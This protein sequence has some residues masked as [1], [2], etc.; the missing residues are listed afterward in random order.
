MDLSK[1]LA[2]GGYPGLFKMVSQMKTG[3]VVESIV[4]GKRM[5]AY[6]TQKILALEDISIYT[7]A[8]DVPL[9]EVFGLLFKKTSGKAG[10]DAQKASIKELSEFLASVLPNYDKAR[11]YNS[12]LKKLFVWFNLLAEKG[13]LKEKEVKK[14]EKPEKPAKE[15]AAAKATKAEKAETPKPKSEPKGKKGATKKV[16]K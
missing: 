15:K 3:I 6:T 5:A 11:V 8:D 7:D 4:D 16:K 1:I 2:I 14:E 9:G 13:L 10:P 12:D